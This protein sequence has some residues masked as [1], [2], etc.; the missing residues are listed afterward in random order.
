MEAAVTSTSNE[1]KDQDSSLEDLWSDFHALKKLYS[2]LQSTIPEGVLPISPNGEIK[3]DEK[4]RNLLKKLLDGATHQALEHQAKNNHDEGNPKNPKVVENQCPTPPLEQ[5]LDISHAEA[6]MQIEQHKRPPC[7]SDGSRS[8]LLRQDQKKTRTSSTHSRPHNCHHP[9]GRRK[10][11]TCRRIH[12]DHS[13]KR[14]RHRSSTQHLGQLTDQSGP[15]GEETFCSTVSCR[16]DDDST[17]VNSYAKNPELMMMIPVTTKEPLQSSKRLAPVD[18]TGEISR[19][20]TLDRTTH[21]LLANRETEELEQV[22]RRQQPRHRSK[23]DKQTSAI[24]RQSRNHQKQSTLPS[25]SYTKKDTMTKKNCEAELG[26]SHRRLQK[27]YRRPTMSSHNSST[28]SAESCRLSSRIQ[29]PDRRVTSNR[30]AEGSSRRR[31]PSKDRSTLTNKKPLHRSVGHHFRPKV[32]KEEKKQEGQLKRLKNKLAIIF[33]HHHHHHHHHLHSSGKA[34]ENVSGHG[35]EDKVVVHRDHSRRS[36][37]EYLRNIKR[38]R[39]Q[40]DDKTRTTARYQVQHGQ[41]HAL[42][43]SIIQHVFRRRKQKVALTPNGRFRQ[44][45]R[46]RAKKVRWWQRLRRRVR[47]GTRKCKKSCPV[48]TANKQLR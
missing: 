7:D 8:N 22:Q 42:L 15:K 41:L 43:E 14:S 46:V 6:G 11:K 23:E 13:M 27:I 4:S 10:E 30:T 32:P 36:F 21:M 45:N 17:A 1:D 18:R 40:T 35:Q 19:S 2:L 5:S 31:R 20:A 33:H 12:L 48:L 37:W 38:R 34:G 26:H 28:S 24:K 44:E 29:S 9:N 39:S 47:L 3:L 16:F 25:S